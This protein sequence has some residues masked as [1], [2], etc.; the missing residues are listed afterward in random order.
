M[1]KKEEVGVVEVNLCGEGEPWSLCCTCA[2]GTTE[3][4]ENAGILQGLPIQMELPSDVHSSLMRAGLVED[5]YAGQRELQHRWI[6]LSDWSFSRTVSLA[7]ESP[8]LLHERVELVCP[9][10]DTV[11]Q[12]RV[13]GKKVG[14]TAKNMFRE[15]RF[16]LQS[17]AEG[18]S[19]LHA[20]ENTIELLFCSAVEYCKKKA[21]KAAYPVP[22]MEYM[23]G[24]K[25][26]GWI[27]KRGCDF[28]W[29]WGPCFVPIGV[30]QPIRLCAF[31]TAVI[32]ALTC[33][34]R[35]DLSQ[36]TVT[37]YFGIHA[38]AAR[39]CV[40]DLDLQ[41][42][43]EA[44]QEGHSFQKRLQGV[45]LIPGNNNL[46]S[47][48][49]TVVKPHLWW[50]VGYGRQSLYRIT[51]SLLHSHQI[52]GDEETLE[53]TRMCKT[54]GL[55]EVQLMTV[56]DEDGETFFVKVNGVPIFA[57]GANWIPC[58]CFDARVTNDHY[59][60][61]LRSA[62]EAN[63]NSIRIWGGGMY[64]RDAFYD[65]CDRFG[66]IV[67]HDFM[68]ACSLYPSTSS[69][70]S[71]VEAEV[72][73]QL[74]RLCSHPCI[75]LWF[76]NNENEE[77]LV[78]GYWPETQSSEEVKERYLSDYKKLYYD[79]IWRVYVEEDMSLEDN[80]KKEER[81]RMVRSSSASPCEG[82]SSART[83]VPFWPSSP[84]NGMFIW[85]VPGDRTRGDCH[86]WA[87]WHGD[88]PLSE[89]LTVCP[90]FCSEFGFQSFPSKRTLQQ[91][92]IEDEEDWNVT[93][94]AM[95][96]RQRSPQRGNRAIVDHIL[97]HFRMPIS[98]EKWLLVS[99]F[100]Q[101]IS[102]R[103]AAEHWRRLQPLCMG[104]LY[105]QLN[106]IWQGASWSS[107]EYDGSWKALHYHAKHFFAPTLLSC[108]EKEAAN[109]TEE[110]V[111]ESLLQ[112]WLTHDG[113][114]RSTNK[115][116]K[117]KE[118]EEKS[119][120]LELSVQLWSFEGAVM[121][122]WNGKHVMKEEQE[123]GSSKA[124]FIASCI[125]EV[126]THRG[127]L[128][129][130]RDARFVLDEEVAEQVS[131]STDIRFTKPNCFLYMKAKSTQREAQQYVNFHF[132]SPFKSITLKR[133]QIQ[134]HVLAQEEQLVHLR[135]E[136][137]QVALFVWLSVSSS[138][139]SS[140]SSCSSCSSCSS[141]SPASCQN[142]G[143]KVVA[144][145]FSNNAFHLL[146]KQPQVVLFYPEAS[147]TGCSAA[148]RFD[149]SSL[150]DSFHCALD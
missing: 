74:R 101:A 6:A 21:T 120:Q 39:P 58:D 123:F 16:V 7:E 22:T 8:L 49:L 100:L 108:F 89:Y 54:T 30:L 94:P 81:W 26:R 125:D 19:V 25:H 96:F 62:V 47:L 130:I 37:C 1:K 66:L 65:L 150:F 117:E 114:Q 103:T 119:E 88:K 90:R 102:I 46:L 148:F 67:W 145:H 44:E 17:K 9:C 116:E 79:T 128:S 52:E 95:E 149:V 83:T 69:F 111:R 107:L 142:V 92:L 50:P 112:V 134:L 118:T 104:V 18:F 141:S 55:R 13:N 138:S 144:G 140:S 11:A 3:S 82:N 38:T 2:R 75:V 34:Q 106:D 91:V 73:Y 121:K 33:H 12:L 41:L 57:K 85:G 64:E 20:G 24:E 146:P 15:H 105:W 133:P 143:G 86:Y 135:V 122:E 72:R 139:S 43:S 136:S 10:L 36:Q 78:G 87:V 4:D 77:A 127:N 28:G 31:S 45:T 110:T 27:R 126:S 32:T 48:E 60:K 115:D 93:S 14:S 98:F 124:V 131:H 29:D 80:W 63:V 71:Q 129:Y 70:L 113:R 76:G 51:A 35:H 40:V 68:F 132:F 42:N 56:P 61:L 147:L 109:Q 99:Q 84:S 137:D 5:L 97:R 23:N 59:E 53:L